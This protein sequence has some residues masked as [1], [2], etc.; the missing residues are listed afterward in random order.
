MSFLPPAYAPTFPRRFQQPN[1]RFVFRGHDSRRQPSAHDGF[2]AP[3]PDPL[4]HTYCFNGG[5]CLARFDVDDDAA[6]SDRFQNSVQSQFDSPPR[7]LR[8]FCKCA[9]NYHGRR[10]ERLFDS[11]LYGFQHFVPPKPSFHPTSTLYDLNSVDGPQFLAQQVQSNWHILV[12]VPTVFLLLL[13]W[14]FV[15]FCRRRLQK[16][17]RQVTDENRTPI[18]VVSV[19]SPSIEPKI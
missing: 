8:A 12:L 6:R 15:V 13:L 4:R 10:C 2:A 9:P 18:A 1:N 7:R 14:L 16:R 5:E 3:C 19:R 11:D 17:G